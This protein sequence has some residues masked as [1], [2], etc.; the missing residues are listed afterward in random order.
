MRREFRCIGVKLE[1]C[2]TVD[3][4]SI[5]RRV[6]NSNWPRAKNVEINMCTPHSVNSSGDLESRC[7]VV[8]HVK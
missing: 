8:L 5:I 4:T 6:C 1:R 7:H 2:E 3:A